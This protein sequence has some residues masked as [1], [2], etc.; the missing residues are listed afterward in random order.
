MI[1]GKGSAKVRLASLEGV[2]SDVDVCKRQE[3]LG[4]E[5]PS[6]AHSTIRDGG[7]GLKSS[8]DIRERPTWDDK[9]YIWA[10]W[11]LVSAGEE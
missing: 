10:E 7:F 4:P 6:Q 5:A 9:P 8:A 3:L 11:G 2:A 1:V